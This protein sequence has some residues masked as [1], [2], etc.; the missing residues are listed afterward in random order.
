MGPITDFDQKKQFEAKKKKNSE[1]SFCWETVCSR[2]LIKTLAKATLKKNGLPS[3]YIFINSYLFIC[4]GSS[5]L[6]LRIPRYLSSLDHYKDTDFG[7]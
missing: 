2:G 3:I 4:L 6:K 1:V 7:K 5:L